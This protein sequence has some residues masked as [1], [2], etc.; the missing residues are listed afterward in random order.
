MTKNNIIE[1]NIDERIKIAAA[2]ALKEANAENINDY[3]QKGGEIIEVNNGGGMPVAIAASLYKKGRE[4]HIEAHSVPCPEDVVKD[5]KPHERI[6]PD[7]GKKLS[8]EELKKLIADE[9]SQ[10][11]NAEI[12]FNNEF[13]P[14][15]I[16]YIP[17]I[18][19][20]IELQCDANH[21]AAR[22]AKSS[23][24]KLR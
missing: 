23:K 16:G 20:N 21:N 7:S 24:V 22:N 9:F 2:A 12:E 18:P 15:F 1:N 4:I 14:N 10:I 6:D 11:T 3:L 8:N 5:L 17:A 13:N 19:Q